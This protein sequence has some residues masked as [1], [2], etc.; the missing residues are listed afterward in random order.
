M[1]PPHDIICLSLSWPSNF[2]K[3]NLI[4]AFRNVFVSNS[5]LTQKT[6]NVSHHEGSQPISALPIEIIKILQRNIQIKYKIFFQILLFI[7]CFIVYI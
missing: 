1:L 4:S 2:T 6:Q 5:I 7:E 3:N